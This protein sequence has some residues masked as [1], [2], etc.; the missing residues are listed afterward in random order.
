MKKLHEI[1]ADTTPIMSLDDWGKNSAN[2]NLISEAGLSRVLSQVKSE[3]D[4]AVLTAYRGN[5]T[6]E[7]NIARNRDLRSELNKKRMGPY[8]LVGHWQECQDSSYDYKNCPKNLLKDVIE[9]SY[10]V[11]KPKDMTPE[12][13][14]EFLISMLQ[15]FEQDG[16]VYRVGNDINILEKSG[17]TFKIGSGM[18]I[19]KI[20]QG[21]SQH[22]KKTNV[23]FTFEGVE[24]PSTN[25]G[26]RLF[27]EAGLSYP[28]L[29]AK[30]LQETNT[31]EEVGQNCPETISESSLSRI[32]SHVEGT[33]S[34]GV[35]S[36]FRDEKSNTEN[37][38]RHSELK[39][40]IRKSG[41]GFIE[42]RGGYNGDQ[43][44][45]QEYSLFVPNVS[46]KDIMEFGKAFD[47]HSVIF[48]D[49]K[50]FVLIGTNSSSGFGQTITTFVR[51][52]KSN[53][54]M[55]KEAIKDFFSA[56]AKGSH[57][58]KKFVFNVEERESWS[59]NQAAYSNRGEEPKWFTIIH[60][61]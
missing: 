32:F 28:V 2:N 7:Q 1:Y 15:K 45:V 25:I 11:V 9:R 12:E 54:N 4:F 29:N 46:R 52:G 53:M 19:G 59:F 38:E 13:F 36:A 47:Q 3:Q 27:Q 31:W 6:K 35:V 61:E 26:R 5:Y 10:L 23:P 44:F 57:S 21:Y 30:E 14:R 40:M 20:A 43:G 49:D 41:Y 48:K 42:M 58:G 50:E 16:A 60:D 39:S 55:A 8:Q 56:L 22:V 51:G 34:F 37:K 24:I 17:N 33:G 18:S